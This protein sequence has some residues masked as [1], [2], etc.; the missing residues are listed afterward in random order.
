MRKVFQEIYS[1][2]ILMA[3]RTD[4]ED[5]KKTFLFIYEGINCV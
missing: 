2:F 1:V 3:A 4:K 5:S